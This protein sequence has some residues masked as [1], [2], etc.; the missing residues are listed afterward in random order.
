MLAVPAVDGV[1]VDRHV[2]VPAVWPAA[3]VQVVKLPVTPVT[4]NVTVRTGVVGPVVEVSVTVTVQ[5]DPWYTKTGFV[6]EIVVV[7]G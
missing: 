4:A 7:V 5:V 2:A 1:N 6:Q 3:R